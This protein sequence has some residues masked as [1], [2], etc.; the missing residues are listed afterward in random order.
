MK[1]FK[2][3]EAEVNTYKDPIT[4]VNLQTYAS[5]I[6]VGETVPVRID[7]PKYKRYLFSPV[8]FFALSLWNE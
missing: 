1:R 8:G 7:K 2:E 5:N 4:I 3:A 6:I